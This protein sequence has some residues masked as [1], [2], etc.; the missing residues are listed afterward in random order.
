MSQPMEIMFELRE[1]VSR[2]DKVIHSAPQANHKCYSDPSPTP[3]L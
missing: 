3:A 1:H 2:Q